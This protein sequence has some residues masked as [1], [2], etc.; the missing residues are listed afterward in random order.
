MKLYGY[1]IVKFHDKDDGYSLHKVH[2]T[3]EVEEYPGC[4][5][6]AEE[7]YFPSDWDNFFPKDEIEKV[8]KDV[9]GTNI[10]YLVYLLEDDNVKA[11]SLIKQ[12]IQEE[13]DEL[14][15]KINYKQ[16]LLGVTCGSICEIEEL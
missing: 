4:Y 15:K 1:A 14:Q 2:F 7:K 9:Y 16:E 13:I 12:A 11:M 10:I 6:N 8:Q 3:Q 5:T